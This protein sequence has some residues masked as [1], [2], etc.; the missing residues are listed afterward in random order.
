MRQISAS[1]V[2]GMR[3]GAANQEMLSF[4]YRAQQLMGYDRMQHYYLIIL[5][6][7]WGKRSAQFISSFCYCILSCFFVC[8]RAQ[9][10]APIVIYRSL[11]AKWSWSPV[12]QSVQPYM[13]VDTDAV[14]A[15]LQ[16][17]GANVC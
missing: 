5:S 12:S 13:D 14:S 10:H 6:P 3:R 16:G 8:V 9:V 4:S 7:P 1:F 11:Y 17:L 2:F 15:E